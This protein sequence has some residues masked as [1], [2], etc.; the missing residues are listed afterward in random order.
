[1]S[2]QKTEQARVFY[3]EKFKSTVEIVIIIL[4]LKINPIFQTKKASKFRDRNKN[5]R[6]NYQTKWRKC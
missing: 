2:I 1:L 5:R 3:E 4:F 6:K